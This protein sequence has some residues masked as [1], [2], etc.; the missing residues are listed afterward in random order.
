MFAGAAFTDSA[1]IKATEAVDTLSALGVIDGY[2]DGSFKPNGTVTRAEMAK[3][4]FV[5]WNGGK[6]DASAYQSMNSAFADTK[7][8]WAAGYVNFCASN[9]IIAGKSATKFDPD[10]TVTGQEA[11]KMLL[12]TLGY[13]ATK[14]GL[15]GAGWASK[16]NALADENGLLEDVTTSFTGPCPRQYA[17]QLIYNAIFA[18]TVVL[19]DGEYTKYGTNNSKNPTVGQ[20]YM[21]LEKFTGLFTGDSK[22]NTGLKDGQIYVGGK[23][24][25]YTPANGNALV[26]EMV[27]VLYK[28]SKDGVNGLDKKDT[29]YGIYETDDTTV[30][31]A[32]LGD[33]DDNDGNKIKVD[34]TKYDVNTMSVYFNYVDTNTTYTAATFTS[35]YKKDSADTVKF[36]QDENGKVIAAYITHVEFRKVTGVTSSKISIAGIGTLDIDDDID[37]DSSVAKNDIVAVTTL[38]NANPK[39]DDAFNIIKKADVTTGVKVSA[40]KKSTQVRIG[41]SYAKLANYNN[42]ITA[43]DSN[44]KNTVDLD[45]TYDFVMYGKYWVA[46]KKISASSQ[47]IALVTKK[48]STG[49]DDQV[50]VLALVLAFACAFTMFAGAASYSDQADIKAPTAVDM[51]S[52]LGVINGYTD[53]SFKPNDTVTRAEMAKMIFTIMNGG[54][55][56]ADSYASLPTKFTDLQS[57]GWAQGYVRYLQNTGIIAGKSSTKFAPNDTVT[58]LEAAKMV[59]VAAGY[60]AEKAGLTGAAWAQNTMKYGQLNNL[61]EDV[62]ADLNA[63]LPRQYAAQI[64]YNALDVERVVWSNDIEDFKPAT[65]VDDDKTI[66]GKYMDLVKTDAEQLIS[67]DKTSGK[68]TY[69]IKLVDDVKYG[70]NKSSKEFDKVPTDVSDLIGLKVKVLV[71]AKSNG[72]IDVY[73]VYADKDSKVIA[74]GTLGQTEKVGTVSSDKKVKINGTEYKLD[75]AQDKT[76]VYYVNTGL[77]AQKLDKFEDLNKLNEVAASIKLVDVNGNGKADHAVITPAVVGQ[78]TY[79][80]SKKLTINATGIGSND[81]GDYDIYDGYAKDDWTVATPDT[82]VA[83]GDTA[84]V[85]VDVTTAKVTSVKSGTPKEVKVNNTWYRVVTDSTNE[86]TASIKAGNTYDLA[87]VGNYIVN[88]K[89]TEGSSNDVLVVTDFEQTNND[90]AGTTTQK[91]KAYF[92]DG[93]SKTIEVEKLATTAGADEKDVDS[94]NKIT[95]ASVNK[96]Y[97]YSTRSNGTYTLK[98]LGSGNMAGYDS[99]SNV[100]TG[101]VDSKNKIDGGK[102]LISDDAVVINMY[103]AIAGTTGVYK[104]VKVTTGKTINDLKIGAS[105]LGDVIAYATKKSNGV[106]SARVL[107]ITTG[108]AKISGAGSDY[109]YAYLTADPYDTKDGEDNDESTVFEAWNGSENVVLKTDGKVAHGTL[110]KGSVL[111]YSNDGDKFITVE[112]GNVGIEAVAITGIEAKS[113]GHIV[114]KSNDVNV[115]GTYQLDKDCVYIA[116]NSDDH[117]G[118]EGDSVSGIAKAEE[119]SGAAKYYANAY[120]VVEKN[121]DGTYGDVLAVIYDADSNR[122]DGAN[123]INK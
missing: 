32:T 23:I 74:T 103:N 53:G 17:A 119:V 70:D 50:K 27:K 25:T 106:E 57:A 77:A 34:G 97:T 8:H 100:S 96:L 123:N 21:G 68:D 87:I 10:A 64:L 78:I 72:D 81:V 12:V 90:M 104:D 88:A 20:K 5:V 95:S 40:V 46:A 26:G 38:Y 1:D 9:G 49:I 4:I 42:K 14:A 55:D 69:E 73:G 86:N 75:K 99:A 62:D 66:G 79:V 51:L 31:N 111:V 67:V 54:N 120:V 6:S 24:D 82:Y 28:E 16:T 113:E 30:I 105:G 39:D 59:L 98:A 85:K 22:I 121:S 58:G 56:K 13:D 43:S 101:A 7:N 52:S 83:S 116:V 115:N 33:V 45:S 41:D 71:K 18:N 37:L 89:E 63:A 47:D 2:T 102:F 48:G 15:V 109:S 80:G 92:L 122:L 93:S 94:T 84:V 114:L 76:P 118:L 29:V 91:V 3:M 19:R 117:E 11:A 112:N 110:A 61:F 60:N 44:Y 108:T 107:V 65:D 35:N 36:V